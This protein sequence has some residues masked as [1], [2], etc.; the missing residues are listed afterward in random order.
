MVVKKALFLFLFCFASIGLYSQ[1]GIRGGYNVSSL[2][3]NKEY[4]A[5]DLSRFQLGLTYSYMPSAGK[6]FGLETGLLYTQKGSLNRDYQTTKYKLN[7]LEIPLNLRYL[8]RVGP[9]GIYAYAGLYGGYLTNAVYQTESAKTEI[10][11]GKFADRLD[12]G[13]GLG[14][15]VE[16]LSRVQL[17][18]NWSSG[19]IDVSHVYNSVEGNVT[20]MKNR[21]ASVTLGFLF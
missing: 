17:G 10:E 3:F 4:N 9:I 18:F 1:I 7:Y 21:L 2:R 11:V 16:L 6:G 13:Y 14:L 12:F 20:S 5:P 19:F 15:G 8:L